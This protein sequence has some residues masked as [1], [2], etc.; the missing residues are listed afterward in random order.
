MQEKQKNPS[1]ARGIDEAN[2]AM[3]LKDEASNDNA[4]YHFESKVARWIR[5]Q[6]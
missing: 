1:R 2:R 5:T 4:F 6:E 3:A